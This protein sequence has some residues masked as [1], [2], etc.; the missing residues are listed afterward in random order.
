[1]KRQT[2][3]TLIELIVVA[4]I[5]SILALVFVAT[6]GA[7]D[8]GNLKIQAKQFADDLGYEVKGVSCMSHDSDGDG[9]IS[10][11]IR[12]EASPDEFETLALECAGGL[13]NWKTGCK[14]VKM[15]LQPVR[16]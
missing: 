14:Q 9:Y 6:C 5:L 3:F 10:C 11:T 16:Q 1:M 2:G 15:G 12:Y 13:L 8:Q 4:A 7:G